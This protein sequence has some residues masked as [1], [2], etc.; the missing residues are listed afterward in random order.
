[1]SLLD[2]LLIHALG[3]KADRLAE[4]SH[5]KES[6]ERR[7]V[8]NSSRNRASL[9]DLQSEVSRLR[10]QLGSVTQMLRALVE[11]LH[12]KGLLAGEELQSALEALAAAADPE[13]DATKGE[14]PMGRRGSREP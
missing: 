9:E 11:R 2:V 3:S 12:A 1:M 4:G 14:Q 10:G 6:R 7:D 13:S 5:S 8:G